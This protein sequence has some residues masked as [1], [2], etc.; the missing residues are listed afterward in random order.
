MP[1][2]L[3]AALALAGIAG[4]ALAQ[5]SPPLPAA[6]QTAETPR[7]GMVDNSCP[8][9]RDGLWA[10]DERVLKT[11][12][13]WLCRYRDDDTGI[14][15]AHPPLVVFM[16]DS[17]TEGWGA[18]DPEFFTHGNVD[19]GISGQTSEQM[20]VRFRQ[21]VIALH[22][23]VVHIMAGTNDIA[24]N[25]GPTSPED[26]ENAIRSMV[27]LARAN[28]IAVVLGSIL[29]TN[30]FNWAPDLQPAPWVKNLNAWLRDYARSERLVYADYFAAL[31]G[32]G[33]E[34]PKAYSEDGVH[35]NVTGYALM[36]PIA[37]HAIAEAL[38]RGPGKRR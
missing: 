7:Q 8:A 36:R 24:G 5:A 19:R 16:G 33:G 37:E 6:A 17:I 18:R 26:Y 20:L 29:P 23:R 22:P 28:R 38:R 34:L 25:V 1:S 30:H 14:D 13:A 15:P 10:L 27:D 9:S 11:D 3:A 31:A 2:R 4:P 12:W 35:P 21:D 32:P